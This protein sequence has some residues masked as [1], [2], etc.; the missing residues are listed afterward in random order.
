MQRV[1][2]FKGQLRRICF[3]ALGLVLYLPNSDTGAVVH[4]FLRLIL[5]GKP[6]YRFY[7]VTST[8]NLGGL[9]S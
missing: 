1:G 8:P 4:F 9:C 7:C 6:S 2:L 5:G 3:F